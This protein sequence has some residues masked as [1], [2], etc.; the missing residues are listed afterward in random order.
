[1]TWAILGPILTA[2]GIL[3]GLG[4]GWGVMKSAVK[5]LKES[6]AKLDAISTAVTV[7]QTQQV[8][9][10][11]DVADLLQRVHSIELTLARANLG[12]Q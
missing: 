1:M 2:A 8:R 3:V 11:V 5:D 6:V 7:L 12:L 10:S 9:G 4:V